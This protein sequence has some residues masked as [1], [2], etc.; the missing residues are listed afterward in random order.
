MRVWVEE[1]GDPKIEEDV[2]EE[3]G[4]EMGTR[5]E[6]GEVEREGRGRGVEV[7]EEGRK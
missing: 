2:K 7:R 5:E 6:D 1:I 4:K 3:E